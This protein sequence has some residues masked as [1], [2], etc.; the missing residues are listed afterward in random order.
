MEELRLDQPLMFLNKKSWLRLHNFLSHGEQSCISYF[1]YWFGRAM[2]WFYAAYHWNNMVGLR[3]CS[4]GTTYLWNLNL[5]VITW[6]SVVIYRSMYNYIIITISVLMLNI[7]VLM[8]P[9]VGLGFILRIE[10]LSP[11]IGVFW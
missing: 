9:I 11:N 8:S 7:F 6:I 3:R 5:F 2:C 4:K 10:D 1:G